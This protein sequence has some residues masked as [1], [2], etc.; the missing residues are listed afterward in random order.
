LAGYV[1]KVLAHLLAKKPSE[2]LKYLLEEKTMHKLINHAESRSV[3]ELIV[4]IL[5]HESTIMLEKRG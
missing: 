4:K 3:G 1:S 5:T 2:M